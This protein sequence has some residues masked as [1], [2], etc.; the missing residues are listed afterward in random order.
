M[1]DEEQ[2][3]MFDERIE[4]M[5]KHIKI[6]NRIKSFNGFENIHKVL[7]DI[8]E[9]DFKFRQKYKSYDDK[10][11]VEINITI[12]KFKE[13]ESI[14]N[15]KNMPKKTSDFWIILKDFKRY[16]DSLHSS[17]I[18]RVGLEAFLLETPRD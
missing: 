1:T 10:I 4:L 15:I 9:D 3:R 8:Y 6:I 11:R 5:S 12:D 13:L 14:K 2:N 7:S 18:C 17:L 16:M